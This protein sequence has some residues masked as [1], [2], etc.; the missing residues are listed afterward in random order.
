MDKKLQSKKIRQA[1]IIISL[2]LTIIL[3]SANKWKDPNGWFK[4]SKGYN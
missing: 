2:L 1:G 4:L 3:V